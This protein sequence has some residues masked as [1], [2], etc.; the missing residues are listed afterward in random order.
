MAKSSET[1]FNQNGVTVTLGTETFTIKECPLPRVKRFQKVWG[2]FFEEIQRTQALTAAAAEAGEEINSMEQWNHM[3]DIVLEQPYEILSIL[4]P[5]L[6]KEPF[7]DEDY[8]VT[9][10]Q[11]F[12]AFDKVLEVNRIEWLKKLTPFFQNM[13]LTV[14]TN[15]LLRGT[16]KTEF[17]PES[18]P[19]QE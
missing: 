8:G 16:P 11:V 3:I 19:E 4:I 9:V 14:D 7:E 6:P 17:M 2:T 13:L 12:E 5:D 10:P 15:S 18:S 1:V